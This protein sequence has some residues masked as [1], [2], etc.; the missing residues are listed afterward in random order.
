MSFLQSRCQRC[1]II[2]KLQD[3]LSKLISNAEESAKRCEVPG[4]MPSMQDIFVVGG[5]EPTQCQ[6]M[7]SILDC[8]GE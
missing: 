6:L 1:Y 3:K 4:L 7:T 5:A 2:S 8:G